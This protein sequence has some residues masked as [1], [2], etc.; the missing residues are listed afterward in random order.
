VRLAKNDKEEGIYHLKKPKAR[1]IG[2]TGQDGHQDNKYRSRQSL[3]TKVLRKTGFF[4]TGAEAA[5]ESCTVRSLGHGIKI[6]D[7]AAA[8]E[9]INNR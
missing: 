5:Y 6:G 2:K 3:R 7:L 8:A 9:K 1:E 4:V